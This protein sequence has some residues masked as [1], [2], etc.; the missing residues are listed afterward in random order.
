MFETTS[1]A[2][3]SRRTGDDQVKAVGLVELGDVLLEAEVLDD[4]AGAG[5]EALDVVGEVG[6]DVV[7]VA[8]ELLEGVAAGVVEQ[9]LYRH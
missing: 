9:S 4:L 3:R 7:R 8:L 5:G 6:G 2:G 1:G